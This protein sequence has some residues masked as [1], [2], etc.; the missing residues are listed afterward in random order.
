MRGVQL[1]WFSTP[2]TST[3]VIL[4]SEATKN[5]SDASKIHRMTSSN[6]S[7]PEEKQL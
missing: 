2:S 3:A 1:I 7:M 6:E 4:R 5:L